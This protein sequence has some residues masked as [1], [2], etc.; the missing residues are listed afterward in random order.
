MPA[1]QRAR[2][3]PVHHGDGRGRWNGDAVEPLS[4]QD[5]GAQKALAVADILIRR[6]PGAPAAAAGDTV[7][8]IDF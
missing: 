3:P 5:S 2:A 1:P 6:R 7:E 8:I 4:N